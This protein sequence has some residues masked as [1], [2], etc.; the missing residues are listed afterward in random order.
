MERKDFFLVNSDISPG[1]IKEKKEKTYGWSFGLS[2]FRT[3]GLAELNNLE[4]TTTV[5]LHTIIYL[6]YYIQSKHPSYRA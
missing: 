3:L 1:I 6:S 2:N 5:V 4:S